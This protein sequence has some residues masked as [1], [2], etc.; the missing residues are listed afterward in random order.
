MSNGS[1]LLRVRELWA[2]ARVY[3]IGVVVVSIGD[4]V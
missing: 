4:D 2:G 3:S 1:F